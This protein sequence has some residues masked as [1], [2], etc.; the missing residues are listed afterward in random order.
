MHDH[1]R[2][3]LD[4]YAAILAVCTLLQYS[5]SLVSWSLSVHFILVLY[6]SKRLKGSPEKK[7]KSVQSIWGL[8][9]VSRGKD[10]KTVLRHPS[11]CTASLDKPDTQQPLH[12]Y[13]L[14]SL[15]PDPQDT[16]MAPMAFI[17]NRRSQQAVILSPASCSD[18][19]LR[20]ARHISR[21]EARMGVHICSSVPP[22]S[23]G[24]RNQAGDNPSR[25][26]GCG[27]SAG[28]WAGGLATLHLTIALRFYQS[29]CLQA[30]GPVELNFLPV[31]SLFL[32]LECFPF[33]VPISALGSLGS[34]LG[35]TY[36]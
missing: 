21:H 27:L 30:W 11:H 23:A 22:E 2:D 24:Q 35:E 13:V 36:Q 10:A 14:F 18:S 9:V 31:T 12:K 32:Q 29:L 8:P 1:T 3:H 16:V 33:L 26:A 34:G 20:A 15:L 6:V 7:R 25:C 28:W 19:A 4:G 17:G 5:F